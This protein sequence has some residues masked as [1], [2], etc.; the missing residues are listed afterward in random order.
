MQEQQAWLSAEPTLR[1]LEKVV[2]QRD[3][4]KEALW[5]VTGIRKGAKESRVIALEAL[6]KCKELQREMER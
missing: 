3:L 1:R 2:Q 6:E 4:L 5:R